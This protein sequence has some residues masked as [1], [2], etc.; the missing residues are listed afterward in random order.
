MR[1]ALPLLVVLA[2]AVTRADDVSLE[3]SAEPALARESGWLD[4]DPLPP[5]SLEA[6]G[7]AE[8]TEGA[9]AEL[10]PG[11]VLDVS[12]T[13]WSNQDDHRY[14]P[15]DLPGRGWRAEARIHVA[16]G[17]GLV[18]SGHGLV[19]Q[20]DTHFARG[21]HVDLALALTKVHRLSRWMTGWISLG[22]GA[23]QWIGKPPDGEA[24]SQ[25]FTLSVGTTFK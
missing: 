5:T 24:D 9:R 10:F 14:T 17:G 2:P 7:A 4:F 11:A 20:S 25:S 13:E 16:L 8:H 22:I 6:M 12:G 3:A 19:A 23:R 21:R 15:L 1:A 18:L